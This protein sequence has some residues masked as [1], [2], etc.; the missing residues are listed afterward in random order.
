MQ[1]RET[2]AALRF[3]VWI[4]R[5]EDWLPR[6]LRD[7]PPKATAVEPAEKGTMNARDAGVYIEAFNRAAIEA[8]RRLWAVAVPVVV[9]YEGEPQAGDPLGANVGVPLAATPSTAERL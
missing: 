2:P 6:S 1:P 9:R 5:Y 7:R 3:R 4:T 8:G